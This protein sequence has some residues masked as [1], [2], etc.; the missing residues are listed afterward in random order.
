MNNTKSK[1]FLEYFLLISIN[2]S[3]F[4]DGLIDEKTKANISELLDKNYI[5]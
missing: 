1:K 2:N 4:R 3:L 5:F